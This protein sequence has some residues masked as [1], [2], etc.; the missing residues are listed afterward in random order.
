[1]EYKRGEFPQLYARTHAHVM[2]YQ[3][4][5]SGGAFLRHGLVLIN[6][7]IALNA[8][9][10]AGAV[11]WGT[12]GTLRGEKGAIMGNNRKRRQLVTDY[13]ICFYAFPLIAFSDR[14]PPF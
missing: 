7:H 4:L 11:P 5:P 9:W 14:W 3:A 10:G 6:A 1:M 13:F 12:G 2:D 8:S